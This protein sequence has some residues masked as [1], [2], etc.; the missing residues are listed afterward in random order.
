LDLRVIDR[1]HEPD[2]QFRAAL[3][4]RLA[5]IVAG[6]D[7][8]PVT[9]ARDLARID[10]EPAPTQPAP[11]RT[12][13]RVVQVILAAASVVAIALVVT[14][15][16][17]TPADQ[18]TVTVPTTTPVTSPRPPWSPAL[19]ARPLEFPISCLADDHGCGAALAVSQDGTLVEYDPA[20]ATLTWYEDEPRVVPITAELSGV[21]VD[22]PGIVGTVNFESG[23]GLLAIGPHDVAYFQSYI[24]RTVTQ[25]AR[26]IDWEFVAVTPSGAEITRVSSSN[27]LDESTLMP[28]AQGLVAMRC[29]FVDNRCTGGSEWPSPDAPVAMPWV[30]LTGNQ[31]TDTRPY[32]A[33]KGTDRGIEVRFGDREWLVAEVPW[34][35]HAMPQ[36]VPR[37]DGGVVLLHDLTFDAGD[38][39]IELFELLPDGT[40]EHFVIPRPTAVLPD[41]S[42]IVYDEPID[43]F[44]RLLD[45]GE[46]E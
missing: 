10:L 14:R 7:P 19:T 39:P 31:I 8:G 21:Q 34:S 29:A 18:P 40:I 23:P 11:K 37:S 2:P 13:R 30:D 26:P 41:G 6:T 9:A 4:R 25:T 20:T 17:A 33:A 12:R 35:G 32:P 28:T 24:P 44:F 27:A 46:V 43:Q 22:T 38:Q 45:E 1:R 16:D 3:Q 36:V 42:V 5:S 15:D